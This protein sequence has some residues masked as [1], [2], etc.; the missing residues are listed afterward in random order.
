MTRGDFG[1]WR[2]SLGT[3]AQIVASTGIV[4]Y[5]GRSSGGRWTY[6]EK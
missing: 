4:V 5:G 2:H 3:L 1:A 6:E